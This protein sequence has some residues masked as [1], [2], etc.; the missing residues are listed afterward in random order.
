MPLDSMPLAAGYLKSYA[1]SQEGLRAGC[2]I[3]VISFGGGKRPLE[4]LKTVCFASP[5][6]LL[7]FSVLGW[8]YKRFNNVV[9]TFKQYCPDAWVVYGGNHVS[10]QAA[11][12]FA[13]APGVDV[14]V[15]GEGEVTFAELLA[16]WLGGAS[17]HELQNVNG[18]SFKG[19]DGELVTTADRERLRELDRIP[20]PVLSGA[21][22]LLDAAG[23]FRYDVALME[24]N[25]GCPYKCAFCYWGGAIG[26]KVRRFSRER[27]R[28][29]LELYARLGVHN[30][31]LCDANFGAFR[32]DRDFVEDLI[33]LRRDYGAPG[34]FEVCWAK[35]KS[36]V[37][38]EIVRTMHDAGLHSNFTLALQSLNGDALERM[39]RQNMKLN[40]W[41]ELAAWLRREGLDCY[42][43]L[44]WGCPGETYE[45]F[46]EGY[47]RLAK[48]VYRIAT[49]PTL[50]LPNTEYANERERFGFRTVRGDHDDYE[51]VLAHDTMSVEDNRRM[52]HFL[53][54]A[55]VFAEYMVFRRLWFMLRELEN[56]PQSAVLL[57][58]DAWLD[59]QTD[60]VGTALRSLRAEVVE[61]LDLS[62]VSRAIRY[63]A[64][65]PE[66]DEY[67]KRWWKDEFSARLSGPTRD[68][69]TE[70]FLYDVMTRALLDS[71][72]RAL[73]VGSTFRSEVIGGTEYLVLTAA[74]FR[75]AVVDLVSRIR[76]GERPPLEPSTYQVDLYYRSGFVNFVDNHE[77]YPQYEGKLRQELVGADP[78]QPVFEVTGDD[79]R[80][81]LEK[82]Q[83]EYGY[84]EGARAAAQKSGAR[85]ALIQLAR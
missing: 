48:H 66:L 42:A 6:D 46:I 72:A 85:E 3:E 59:R 41:E 73:P 83:R 19:P 71:S 77:F 37:F 39:H 78:E 18:I 79:V 61:S 74:P 82:T 62:R 44:M 75:Y 16:A 8:N 47:D 27:L 65:T 69:L 50:V 24:T 26:Q 30:V 84:G 17:R 34:N 31:A 68:F 51:Y 11:R 70:V 28:A 15:N 45:S 9:E 35:N 57:S 49:Y 60:T 32:E 21:I 14:V 80:L 2:D 36:K 55:R 25:R 1:Y 81:E 56:I 20:S 23:R 5:P 29:E 58:L 63:V 7:A 10:W 4:M 13:E 43:E 38:F 76:A 40:A 54:W 22:P 67:L 12:V 64:A 53:F 52:H 33:Q